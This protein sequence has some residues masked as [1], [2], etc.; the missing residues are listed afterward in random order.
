VV[1]PV[2]RTVVESVEW[3]VVEPVQRTKVE[4]AALAQRNSVDNRSSTM[5]ITTKCSL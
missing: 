3:T 4:S 2:G 5:I 1:E